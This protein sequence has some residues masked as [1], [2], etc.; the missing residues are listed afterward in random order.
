MSDVTAAFIMVTREGKESK[1][2][3]TIDYYI[4]EVSTYLFE[5][6]LRVFALEGA[7]FL[8]TFNNSTLWVEIG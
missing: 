7:P 8:S 4:D 3:E 2:A 1:A 6:I 5:P